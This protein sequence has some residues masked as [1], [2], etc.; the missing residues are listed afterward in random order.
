MLHTRAWA[1]IVFGVL[2]AAAASGALLY[3]NGPIITNPTGGTGGIAGLPIS[4][5]DSFT[6][7]GSSLLYYTTGI[8]LSVAYNT[9]VAED[10]TVPESGWKVDTLTVYAFQSGWTTPSAQAIHVNIWNATPYSAGSPPPVPDPLPQPMLATSLILPAGEGRFVCHRQGNATGTSTNRPVFAYTVSL[11]GLPNHGEL[12]AGTYWMQWAIVGASTPTA[13]IYTPLVSPRT[14]V[15]NWNARLYNSLT[16]SSTGPRDWF[17]GRE[18]YSAGVSE[19]RPYALPF[20]LDGTVLPEP[21]TTAL[22]VLAALMRR[23]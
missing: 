10:F 20:Q 17:E 19:G 21:A 22:L 4:N 12:P 8:G 5:P 7:P 3:D 18:G 1:V 23:R 16:G 11:D 13:L 15:S 14:A 6:I 9:A 2:A